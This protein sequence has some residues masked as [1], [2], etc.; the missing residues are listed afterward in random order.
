[1]ISLSPWRAASR[2]IWCAAWRGRA[3]GEIADQILAL[4]QAVTGARDLADIERQ[5][6]E[7]TEK[8][9]EFRLKAA[10]LDAELEEAYLADRQ[11][12]RDM[13]LKLAELGRT[14]WMMCA[15]G[16][17]VVLGFVATVLSAF[18]AD[19]TEQQRYLVFSLAGLLGGMSS[20]VVSY[21]FGSSR[22]SA[23][24]TRLMSGERPS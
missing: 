19:L 21:F 15:V 23:E 8:A 3:R 20:Q 10:D 13:R 5:L 4:A 12:A 16:A 14:D 6:A 11:D 1:L 7:D 17:I 2:R 24:K 9:H 18:F 22:G